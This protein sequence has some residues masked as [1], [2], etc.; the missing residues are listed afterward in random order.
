MSGVDHVGYESRARHRREAAERKGAEGHVG[1]HR[2]EEVPT[3]LVEAERLAHEGD[4]QQEENAEQHGPG[5]DGSPRSR[6]CV[7]PSSSTRSPRR[8]TLSM[9]RDPRSYRWAQISRDH[10]EGGNS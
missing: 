3:M 8:S 9:G 1:G 4:E 7:A 5:R 10:H 6:R 2:Y